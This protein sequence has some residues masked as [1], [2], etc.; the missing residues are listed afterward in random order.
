MRKKRLISIILSILM[1]FISTGKIYASTVNISV[2]SNKSQVIVGDTVTVTVKLSSS[3]PLGSW[4]FIPDYN[5]NKLKLT[6]GDSNVV[7]YGNGKLKSKSYTYKFKAIATGSSSV[8]VKVSEMLDWSERN[9][10]VKK[11][12]KTIKVITQSE[13]QASLSKN[14]NLSSLSVSGLTLSPAF[15][16]NTTS[17]K[18]QAGANTTSIKLSAKAE[19]SR[20][21]VDGTGTF[22][23]SEGDNKFVVT[24]TAQNG[25]TKKYTVI[26]SVIDPN[27]IRVTVEDKEYVL[28]KREAN[29]VIPDNYEKKDI[30]INNQTVPGFYNE[31]NG[32]TLVGLKDEN[33]D[34][35]LFIYEDDNYTHYKEV[36]LDKIKLLP[37]KMDMIIS[38]YN[39]TSIIV[40]ETE[41]EALQRT[42]SDYAV[43]HAKNLD[44]GEENY[45]TYDSKTN[46][47]VRY[48]DEEIK[49]FIATITKYKKLIMI[50]II[51]TVF[52]FLILI[53][54]LISKVHKNKIRKQK[55]EE[56][57]KRK[58]S[59]LNK[60]KLKKEK[61]KEE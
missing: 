50:L 43:I 25:S 52:I 57:K 44:T 16:K 17:Y 59:E 39:K 48:T 8:T 23:V 5:K 53:G 22:K 47:L 24:V 9:M 49:P 42:N 10:T 18:V 35:D 45:Y 60:R 61:Q 11:G 31:A 56:Y 46:T 41:F 26:V 58:E 34:V 54:I 30:T 14:N 37:L 20:S 3:T 36:E 2:S 38:D 21:D 29:L 28:V 7:D 27:P 19:D 32:Y 4:K 1:L 40:D 55:I 12:S 51:E 33:G 13:Y 6:S 15:N